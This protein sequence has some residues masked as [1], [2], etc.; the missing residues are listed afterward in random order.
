VDAAPFYVLNGSCP[1]TQSWRYG[2]ENGQSV[3]GSFIEKYQIIAWNVLGLMAEWFQ[4]LIKEVLCRE[5]ML[6]WQKIDNSET[7]RIEKM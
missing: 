2:I 4:Y 7:I 5:T 1:L 3:I 6:L